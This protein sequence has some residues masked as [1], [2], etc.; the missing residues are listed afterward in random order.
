LDGF[1]PVPIGFTGRVGANDQSAVTYVCGAAKWCTQVTLY[2]FPSTISIEGYTIRPA[3]IVTISAAT[4]VKEAYCKKLADQAK[5]N[6]ILPG[7]GDVIYNRQNVDVPQ[8]LVSGLLESIFG[9][10]TAAG[11]A[12][13]A[14]SNSN[15]AL[16]NIRS[17]TGVPMTATKRFFFWVGVA[18]NVYQLGNAVKASQDAYQSCIGW[19]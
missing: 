1:R 15:R 3:N 19:F 11:Q 9:F 17:L 2:S 14:T 7:L 13:S 10:G 8:K 12:M 5:A 6:A 16:S 4:G 18:Q